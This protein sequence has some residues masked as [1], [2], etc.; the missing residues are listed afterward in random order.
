MCYSALVRQNLTWL[1]KR[2]GAE[3][4][5]DLF[6]ELFRRRVDDDGVQFSRALDVHVM[7]MTD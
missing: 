3:V 5:W 1:A 4:A 2:Y 7:Q 6:Q